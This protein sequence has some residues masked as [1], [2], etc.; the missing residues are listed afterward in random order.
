MSKAQGENTMSKASCVEKPYA[1]N[2]HVRPEG[3]NRKVSVALACAA[4]AVCAA[5]PA[6]A[7][8]TNTWI[9]ATGGSWGVGGN[10]SQN[11]IPQ[12]S[13]YVV[14]PD[15]G[16]DYSISV[17][18]NYDC[19][20]F[21]VDNRQSGK[22]STVSITLIGS[23]SV[24]A[25]WATG[26][27]NQHVVRQYRKLVLDGVSLSLNGN[28]LLLYTGLELKNG[29]SYT[30]NNQLHFR[31]ASST[32][33]VGQ[34]CSL[35]TDNVYLNQSAAIS[36]AGGAFSCGQ[37]TVNNSAPLTLSVSSNGS[38]SFS[39]LL[40]E[41]TS[42][43][44]VSSGSV[45]V[46]SGGLT[47]A[48]TA[49]LNLA[50]GSVQVAQ[51]VTSSLARLVRESRGTSI[52]T[53]KNLGNITSAD[54]AA[55]NVVGQGETLV[56]AG[57]LSA[58][59]GPIALRDGST[60]QSDCPVVVKQFFNEANIVNAAT[61][62]LKTIVFGGAAILTGTGTETASKRRVEIE[63]PT[64]M[65]AFAD[66]PKL[67]SFVPMVTGAITVDTRDWEDPSV[68]RNV[69]F[70]L[71]THTSASLVFQ[72]GGTAQFAHAE[73]FR[74]AFS[75]ITV[76]SGTTLELTHFSD[77]YADSVRTDRFV[78]GP[79][80]VLKIPAGTNS[81]HAG[82]WDIDPTARIEVI[83]PA[84]FAA[85]AC[86]LL[87]DETGASLDGYSSQVAVTGAGASGWSVSH[88]GGVL[89]IVK[90]AGA[91]DGTYAY[92]WTGKGTSANFSEASNWY[93]EETPLEK[94]QHVFGAA[95]DVTTAYFDN[96]W[97]S[98]GKGGY[99]T[100]GYT[101]GSILFRKTAVK[102]FTLVADKAHMTLDTPGESISPS[103]SNQ[104]QWGLFSQSDLPQV[105]NG[106]GSYGLRGGQIAIAAG[107]RGPVVVNSSLEVARRLTLGGDVRFSYPALSVQRLIMRTATEWGSYG[108]R[109]TLLPGA[110]MTVTQ[111]DGMLTASASGSM[112]QNGSMLNVEAGATLTFAAGTGAEYKWDCQSPGRSVV[113]G[114]LDV[115][116]PYVNAAN[117][118]YGGSGRINVSEFRC[119]S[120]AG[121]LGLAGTVNLYPP[122][123]WNTVDSYG[124]N[125]PFVLKA[126]DSP[127]VHLAGDWTYGP[128]AAV[129]G[130]TTTTASN[131][132]CRV[133]SDA[134]LTID[135]GG[136]V[137]TF[138][139]PVYGFGALA[140]TNGTL[141]LV[142]DSDATL[143]LSVRNGG[144]LA[145]S[146][147]R[148]VRSLSLAAGAKLAF[149]TEGALHVGGD[150]DLA[151]VSV[152]HDDESFAATRGWYT[153]MSSSGSISGASTGS[154]SISLRVVEAAGGSEL[155]AR[156][157]RGAV[158]IVF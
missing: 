27:V 73:P 60:L 84:G 30:C 48:D 41:S 68:Q 107:G 71:G 153:V 53:T 57:G 75:S 81:V 26:S 74:G 130:T 43:L 66:I 22:S 20:T 89:A 49:T 9:G 108:T 157:N 15:K 106:T 144:T 51:E 124:A 118:V 150:V 70:S 129:S 25:T 17:D 98:D 12:T 44:S 105:V 85:G 83:V 39:K 76:S 64:T 31:A 55:V 79:G 10:W 156:Y 33:T 151:G 65:R 121:S 95:D 131:R 135:G 146:T 88:Q 24:T 54:A 90:S 5:L 142:G 103:P 40:L 23:G 119:S 123:A 72:G 116:A 32:V 37:M 6:S 109:M 56:L 18:G 8:V 46:G 58:K 104:G 78:L 100:K 7:I 21:Y 155:Q 141:R 94:K 133:A 63:G 80:S 29:A 92:E 137:A 134:T 1:R 115:L 126:Y 122:A 140:V 35:E 102:T 132:A 14:F 4:F 61:L 91:V 96:L 45:S 69:S 11:H 145:W 82:T 117:V 110:S 19:G 3:V 67:G 36:V 128:A 148:T 147:A 112:F 50:G 114:T 2:Q 13:E 28:L 158:V 42:S 97:K 113:D 139:D 138:A 154:S 125:S 47:L 101:L 62:R 38:V 111:Q 52:A 99:T 149:P 16:S 152:V 136:H 93:C 34:G 87:S 120:A 127:T 143:A 86:A 77:K 59:Y